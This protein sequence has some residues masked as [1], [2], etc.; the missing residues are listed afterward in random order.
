M[1]EEGQKKGGKDKEGKRRKEK[2]EAKADCAATNFRGARRSPVLFPLPL[3]IG[4]TK[5]MEEKK[6]REREKEP[7]DAASRRR[8]PSGEGG[9]K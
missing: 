3:D 9:T 1:A 2:K 6:K 8:S 7:T 4:W 5:M